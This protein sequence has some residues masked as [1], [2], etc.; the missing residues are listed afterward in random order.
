MVDVY[1]VLTVVVAFSLAAIGALTLLKNNRSSLNRS[2]FLFC[3]STAL[4][5]VTNYLSNDGSLPH[6]TLLIA[7]HLVL[8]FGGLAIGYLS[9]YTSLLSVSKK[10]QKIGKYLLFTNLFISA[11][12]L[13]PL[14]VSSIQTQGSVIAID[15]GVA[16]PLYF[17]ALFISVI[18]AVS[19][20]VYSY[21]KSQGV[22]K[23]KLR[24]ILAGITITCLVSLGTNVL[25]P[26][27]GY[28]GLTN[29]G[30]FSSIFMVLGMLYAIIRHHLFDIRY[31]VF[32]L[33]AYTVSLSI[34]GILFI[35]VVFNLTS[36]I[37]G[38]QLISL[39]LQIYYMITT[40]VIALMYGRIKRFVDA[41]TNR[42]FFQQS[43]SVHDAI[44]KISSF[45]TRSVDATSIQRHSLNVF[46]ET[47]RP[48]YGCFIV[49]DSNGQLKVATSS[50][51]SPK[52]SLELSGFLEK[53]SKIH[54]KITLAEDVRETKSQL[55]EYFELSN[56][57]VITRLST[58]NK[59]IGYLILGEKKNGNNYNQHDLQLLTI[60]A[61]D[62]ALALQN[63]LAF[64]QIQEFNATL[65][66]KVS[67]ATA[68]LKR[69]ND[70]LVALDDTKDEFI[71]MASHQLRT[72]LTSIK[73]YISMM[74]EGDLGKI[75]PTQ[76]QALEEAFNSSQRMVFLISD[77]LNVSRIRT[78]KFVM[79]KDET[80]LNQIVVEEITQLRE[81][82]G[83]RDQTINYKPPKNFPKV[84][85]DDTKTRQ[86]MMNFIDNAIFYTPKNGKIDIVLEQTDK[87][88]IFKVTDT[89][90]GV[91]KNVQHRLFTK[92]FRAEN[93]RNARPDGTGLGLFMGQKI[94]DAQ[95]GK[96]IFHSVEHEGSTFGFRFPIKS[97]KA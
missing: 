62:L 55:K 74:L 41:G 39:D 59:S 40:I 2:F 8:F 95:G 84:I 36:L 77:F 38:G 79:E 91:P 31:V 14:V 92:F 42:L 49:I 19:T 75:N 47:I 17:I 45:S 37:F 23:V 3:L 57:G 6:D 5:M 21:L 78:G 43:Y 46:S 44:G 97:I 64:E 60:A 27:F 53:L 76:R 20:I 15:F 80:D 13:T 51:E 12:T 7:N 63:A 4:W 88:I 72:P 33:L 26:A 56:I 10:G 54:Q 65:Q 87:E 81:L 24:A 70:K 86:V 58:N 85:L 52:A 69:T 18:Y 29:I 9:Y 94:I 1:F 93:A 96:M 90:I 67:K 22:E 61:N 48:Q 32:R 34:I 28:F 73:G 89:G 66:A 16:A 83:L 30:P 11:L 71:S 35:F 25:A 68:A 50:G 82:A